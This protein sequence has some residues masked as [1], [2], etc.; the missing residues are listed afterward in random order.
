MNKLDI[1]RILP[2]RKPMLLVDEAWVDA[3]G[4][5]IGLC[6]VNGDEFYL[7]GHFPGNPVVPGVILCEMMAQTCGVLLWEQ[8]AGKTPYYT[9]LNKVRFRES[10]RPG[11]TVRFDCVITK[12]RAPFFFSEGKGYVGEK[13]CIEGEFSFALLTDGGEADCSPKS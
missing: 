11:D 5:A 7:R 12:S 2:H 9:G 1:E 13:L 10:V 6:S 4:H 8:S 3:E